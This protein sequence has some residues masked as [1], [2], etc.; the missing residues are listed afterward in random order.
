MR[1]GRARC[2]AG[3]AACARLRP[4]VPDSGSL[5]THAI[6]TS[7]RAVPRQPASAHAAGLHTVKLTARALRGGRRYQPYLACVCA[8]VFMPWLRMSS[9]SSSCAPAAPPRWCSRCRR[10][11]RRPRSQPWEPR[12]QAGRL[13]W[14]ARRMGRMKQRWSCCSRAL[15]RPPW[16]PARQVGASGR[17]RLHLCVVVQRGDLVLAPRQLVRLGAGLRAQARLVVC[18]ERGAR[19]VRGLLGH[20]VDVAQLLLLDLRGARRAR[21]RQEAKPSED[22][23]ARGPATKA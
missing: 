17:A 19:R 23:R 12:M 8:L 6:P 2:K 21:C 9:I 14:A 3:A 10:A 1:P 4:V 16:A 18:A 11:R 22:G 15:H 5:L 13:A 20:R 7:T